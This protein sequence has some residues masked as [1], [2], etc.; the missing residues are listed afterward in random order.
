VSNTVAEVDERRRGLERCAP[1]A[2]ERTDGGPTRA[3][4]ARSR[5]GLKARR[6]RTAVAAKPRRPQRLEPGARKGVA[7]RGSSSDGRHPRSFFQLITFTRVG[8]GWPRRPSTGLL[9]RELQGFST[10][11]RQGCQRLGPHALRRDDNARRGDQSKRNVR[12]A[13]ANCTAV[14]QAISLV[15][16]ASHRSDAPGTNE[17]RVLIRSKVKWQ[18][19]VR[20]ILRPGAG[21]SKGAAGSGR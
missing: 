5:R 2:R 16:R 4:T 9:E 19:S 15:T 8:W 3:E 17:T 14:K 6:E 7:G 12:P 21:A 18:K 11:R 10:G 13:E 1:L 20:R